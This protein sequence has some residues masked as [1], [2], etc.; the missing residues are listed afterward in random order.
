MMVTNVIRNQI[1]G[2][3]NR[4]GFDDFARQRLRELSDAS[5]FVPQE[6]DRLIGLL[7]QYVER[8]PEL[9]D[10]CFEAAHQAGVAHE[11]APILEAAAGYFI[12]PRDFIP[13]QMGLFGLL[14]DAYLTHRFV[15]HT[16][17]LYQQYAGRPL[18]QL[19]LSSMNAVAR[20]VIGEPLASQLDQAVDS[21]V[22]TIIQQIQLLALQGQQFQFSPTGGPGA[23]GG[24]WEDEMTRTGAELGISINW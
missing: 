15:A 12:D 5:A 23:W 8:A 6:E 17:E 3:F 14:D 10:A 2:T 4:P 9:L 11:A 7:C 24:T 20:S 1:A 19:D 13:D 16:S 21:T 18:L 22:Q